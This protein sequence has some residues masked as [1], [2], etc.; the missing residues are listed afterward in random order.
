MFYTVMYENV[1][2]MVL[3]IKFYFLIISHHPL[4]V[5]NSLGGCVVKL[6]EF[7]NE[8]RIMTYNIITGFY[9]NNLLVTITIF[10]RIMFQNCKP[11]RHR[12]L[13]PA[14]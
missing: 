9:R 11:T 5:L 14:N 1:F 13:A 4:Y 6:A 12:H 10:K 2:D 3:D 7:K 8:I